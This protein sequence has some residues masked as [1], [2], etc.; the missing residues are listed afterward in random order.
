MHLAEEVVRQSSVIVESA[1]VRAAH[2]TDLQL[3]VT[4]WT[5]C[6]L[7]VFE[8]AL[9]SLLLVL[10]GA[11]LVHLIQGQCDRARLAEHRDFEKA[12][13]DGVVQVGNLFQLE[14]SQSGAL[15]GCLRWTIERTRLLVCW[16]SSGVFSSRR[17]AVSILRSQSSMYFCMSRM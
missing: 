4:R 1:Q 3:L 9:D 17:W 14:R 2:V 5:G 7:Q 16:I 13:V 11:D 12:R 6:I 10:C 8:I 15:Q